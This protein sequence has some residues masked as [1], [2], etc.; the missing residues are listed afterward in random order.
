MFLPLDL[1]FEYWIEHVTFELL[2]VCLDFLLWYSS[3]D[4]WDLEL[5]VLVVYGAVDYQLTICMLV[6]FWEIEFEMIVVWK[7]DISVL[8]MFVYIYLHIS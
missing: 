8:S 2:D 1:V 7:F 4:V 5:I 3:G 6:H